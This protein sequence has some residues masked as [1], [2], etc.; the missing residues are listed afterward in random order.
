M[1]KIKIVNKSKNELPEY[2]HPGDSGL[3]IRANLE[4]AVILNPLE[5]KLIPTGIYM[6]IPEGYEVQVRPRSGMALKRGLTVLNTPGTIDSSFLGEIGVIIVNLSNEIQH[7]LPGEKIAQLV[8]M[9]VEK[10][11]LD[12]TFSMDEL[13]STERGANG[14]GSTG[15]I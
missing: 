15:R 14:Y 4:E 3:D 9:K 11:D 5:R 7:I 6:G 12:L 8:V 13:G 1:I 10:A 2:A